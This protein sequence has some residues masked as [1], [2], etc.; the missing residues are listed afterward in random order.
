DLTLLSTMEGK[1][2]LWLLRQR[3]YCTQFLHFRRSHLVRGP[4]CFLHA[5]FDMSPARIVDLPVNNGR[6]IS[7][8]DSY[9]IPHHRLFLSQ[10]P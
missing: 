2:S 5:T 4:S 7:I 1:G 10:C 9:K 8:E 6:N 3:C